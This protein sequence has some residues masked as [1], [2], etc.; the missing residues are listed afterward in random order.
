MSSPRPGAPAP[1]GNPAAAPVAILFGLGLLVL[2]AICVRDLLIATGAIGGSG[3]LATA[4]RWV[5]RLRW[6]DWMLPAAIVAVLVGLALLFA[7]VKP[8]P[9]THLSL[10]SPAG[11]WLRPTDLARLCSGRARTV[12]G[13]LSATTAVSRKRAVVSVTVGAPAVP[14]LEDQVRAA[15]SAGLTALVHT[16]ELRIAITEQEAS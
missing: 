12:A 6:H 4:F 14:D 7:A 9:H 8:R 10:T 2:A 3:W 15:V 13:V 1:T 5:A 16:P 11:V